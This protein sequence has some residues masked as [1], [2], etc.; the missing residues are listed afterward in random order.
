MSRIAYITAGDELN[1]FMDEMSLRG[2]HQQLY[3]SA[4]K[5]LKDLTLKERYS[6]IVMNLDLPPGEAWRN[7]WNR[8]RLPEGR[9]RPREV[10]LSLI[11]LIK[12]HR[13]LNKATPLIIVAAYAPEK[14]P[15]FPDAKICCL[16]LGAAEYFSRKEIDVSTFCDQLERLMRRT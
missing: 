7:P 4:G 11:E 14:D 16:S 6:A 5:A 1:Y 10:G 15:Q 9:S 3:Q 2:H 13:S 8:T 12:D